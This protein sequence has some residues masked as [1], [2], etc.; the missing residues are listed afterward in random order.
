MDK[1]TGTI[2]SV[3]CAIIVLSLTALSACG[4][5]G[6][7]K[8]FGDATPIPEGQ[9][10]VDV[11]RAIQKE[12]IALEKPV[13]KKIKYHKQW[14]K[15]VFADSTYRYGPFDE[16]VLTRGAYEFYR[17]HTAREIFTALTPLLFDP[18]IGGEVAVMLS[19]IPTKDLEKAS[20]VHLGRALVEMGYESPEKKGVWNISSRIG[21]GYIGYPGVWHDAYEKPAEGTL[22]HAIY[23]VLK[24]EY[25]VRNHPK[26]E[27]F[28]PFASY[29]EG[30]MYS[31][32]DEFIN[33]APKPIPSEAFKQ[34]LADHS[35][36]FS[37]T[38]LL[39]SIRNNKI[40][41][42]GSLGMAEEFWPLTIYTAAFDH[43]PFQKSKFKRQMN[44]MDD[45]FAQRAGMK[46]YSA[47]K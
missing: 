37:S 15:R 32:L 31:T 28:K 18:E 42:M 30:R 26:R 9:T 7:K 23:R 34:F 8:C 44:Q 6:E 17:R 19:G 5:D 38:V 12:F 47:Y 46:L 43:T 1:K 41:L 35:D 2:I 27:Y 29:Y 36:L 14:K 3:L 22:D 24:E 16:V 25:S 40:A 33:T 21:R 13:L 10:P 39:A 20:K 11:I 4:M 45:A